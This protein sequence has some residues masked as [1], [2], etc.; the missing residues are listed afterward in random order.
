M[1]ILNSIM[2]NTFSI[3]HYYTYGNIICQYYGNQ[4]KKHKNK[5]RGHDKIDDTDRFLALA[6]FLVVWLIWY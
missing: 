2:A 1:N 6:H 5:P 4:K 3:L